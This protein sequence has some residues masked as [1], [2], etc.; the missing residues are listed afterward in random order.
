MTRTLLLVALLSATVSSAEDVASDGQSWSVVGSRTAGLNHNQLDAT[1]GYPGVGITYKRGLLDTFDLGAHLSLD[2]GQYGQV[3]LPLYTG[4][5]LQA[6]VKVKFLD[7]GKVNLGVRFTPGMAFVFPPFS[8]T[9]VSFLLPVELRLGIVASS[10]LNVGVGFGLP[11][12]IAFGVGSDRGF[13]I[14]ILIGAGAEYFVRSDLALLFD[15]RMGPTIYPSGR[16][17]E[18]SFYGDFGVGWH[19]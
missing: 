1:V 15:L 12:R 14:P 8:T 19:F 16:A 7:T 4:L 3:R 9:Q 11:M 10:A 17:A 18:F 2:Y 5:G 13:L 6:V